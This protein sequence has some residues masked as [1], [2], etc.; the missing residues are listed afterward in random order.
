MSIENIKEI[1]KDMKL[2]KTDQILHD[3]GYSTY[4]IS[5]MNR[6]ERRKEAQRLKRIQKKIH[7]GVSSA[8]E[9]AKESLKEK[10]IIE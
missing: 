6:A 10:G 3:A 9:S 4:K 8:M 5:M 1:A 7:H 2:S